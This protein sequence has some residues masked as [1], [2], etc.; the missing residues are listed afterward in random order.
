MADDELDFDS[1]F[2]TA[3]HLFL[4]LAAL[5]SPSFTAE[6]SDTP[7]VEPCVIHNAIL[8]CDEPSRINVSTLKACL[9]VRR[10]F[11]A[12]PRTSHTFVPY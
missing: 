2:S 3:F 9:T 6:P 12:S 4:S 5:H 1:T 8:N 10:T 7:S 11:E